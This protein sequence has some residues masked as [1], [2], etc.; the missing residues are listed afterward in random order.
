M[1]HSALLRAS[2]TH[3]GEAFGLAA[4][5]AG[6][7]TDSGVPHAALLIAFA[8]AMIEGD[9]DRQSRARR[10]LHA[11]LGAAALVD[12]AAVVA[13]FNAVVKIADATGI[14]LEESKAAATEALR[15]QLDLDRLKRD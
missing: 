11:A 7:G 15:A 14:P 3:L 13:S 2:G 12:A 6:D 10:D 5:V 8:T 1:S 4:I 9:P